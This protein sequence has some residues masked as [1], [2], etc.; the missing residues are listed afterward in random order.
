MTAP[1]GDAPTLQL[2]LPDNSLIVVAKGVKEDGL[3]A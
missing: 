1:V 3:A 2:K